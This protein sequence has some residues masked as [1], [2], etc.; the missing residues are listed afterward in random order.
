MLLVSCYRVNARPSFAHTSQ[1]K[2]LTCTDSCDMSTG[3]TRC[4]ASSRCSRAFACSSTAMTKA[5]CTELASSKARAGGGEGGILRYGA[6][7][8]QEWTATLHAEYGRRLT[9][10]INWKG[11]YFCRFVR[12]HMEE[13]QHTGWWWCWYNYCAH[14][15]KTAP[16]NQFSEHARMR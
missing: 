5:S 10:P 8:T 3:L 16:T 4:R 7:R 2:T 14:H 15:N 11:A 1:K 12:L 9:G 6:D 13:Q